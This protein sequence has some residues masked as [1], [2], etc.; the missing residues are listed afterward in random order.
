MVKSLSLRVGETKPFH[1]SVNPD[2][3]NKCFYEIIDNN[4]STFSYDRPNQK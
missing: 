4:P 2:S 3:I 1:V